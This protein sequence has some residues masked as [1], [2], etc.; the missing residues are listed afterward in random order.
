[1]THI[2]RPFDSSQS[3]HEWLEADGFGGFASGTVSTAR[4]RRYHA[5]LLTATHP[6]G[7]R[8]VLVNGIEA[9]LEADGKRY[10]L[11]MQRYV[12]DLVYPDISSSLVG[13]DTQPW[14][15]WRF[16]LEGDAVLIAEVFV[17]KATCETVLRWRVER[18]EPG[19]A[20]G[21]TASDY[22]LHVRPLL[23]GRDYHALHHENP[24]FSFNADVDEA[25]A[26]VSWQP[27]GDVP[28]IHASSNGTYTHAPD[29]YRNFC[30]VRERERGLDFSEDLA[31]PG[32]FTFPLA[33]GEAWMILQANAPTD[34][35]PAVERI[36]TLADAECTRRNAFASRLHRSA[37]AYLVARDGGRTLL[38]GFPWFTDWGRDTFIAM[39]GL[40]L[41]SG[42]LEAAEAI[43]L[44]WANTLSEG[45]LPNRF[46]DYGIQ[47]RRCVAVVRGCRARVSGGRAGR[48]HHASAPAAGRRGHS[49]GI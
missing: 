6:P 26:C 38:A 8:M 18:G 14:P 45:M 41:A 30:Y 13:F 16:Q 3:E 15:T 17:A 19:G 10:A 48:R 27:Y 2:D 23:S 20:S 22:T 43:L 9:W 42:R 49:H 34:T 31:T 35:T 32:V 21:S 33:N 11:S 1:M 36:K 4:T 28:V 40:L 12:P 47:R 46:P 29:W 37:D 25:R 7:G 39:R 5:L 44:E 24:A